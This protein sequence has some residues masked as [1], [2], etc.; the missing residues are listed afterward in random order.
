[1]CQYAK[2]AML[3]AFLAFNQVA[4]ATLSLSVNSNLQFGLLLPNTHS[5]AD[6][7]INRD[8]GQVNVTPIGDL[9]SAGSPTAGSYTISDSAGPAASGQV[10]HVSIDSATLTHAGKNIELNQANYVTNL[11]AST[12]PTVCSANSYCGDAML[13]ANGQ[14]ILKLGAT[15]TLDSGDTAGDYT[16]NLTIHMNT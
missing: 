8:S 6:A 5:S 10:V 7:V 1:M 4:M 16:G 15:A 2:I 12:T 11:A 9:V 13:D 14:F 3:V